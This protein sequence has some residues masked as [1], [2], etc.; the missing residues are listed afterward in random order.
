MRI[1]EVRM[2]S[3][4]CP[5]AYDVLDSEGHYCGCFRLRYGFFTVRDEKGD[6]MFSVETSHDSVFS[7]DEG[8]EIY[9]CAAVD[10]LGF[11]GFV[12]SV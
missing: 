1:A 4:A 6:T 10:V 11:D 7:N 5:E 9:L 12:K 3:P 8:R 2:T